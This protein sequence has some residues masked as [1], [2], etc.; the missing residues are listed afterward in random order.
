MII[1]AA[2][3]NANEDLMKFASNLTIDNEEYELFNSETVQVEA[4]KS[5]VPV[6][7]STQDEATK[8]NFER[9]SDKNSFDMLAM[10]AHGMETA[11]P[12]Q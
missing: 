7:G 6:H 2:G 1:A 11:A 3:A 5:K 4:P 8:A 10:F 9:A 12:G